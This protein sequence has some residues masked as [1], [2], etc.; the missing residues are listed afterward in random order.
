VN[1]GD[2][3]YVMSV[4]RRDFLGDSTVTL[5][6][7]G[8]CTHSRRYVDWELKA[9]LRQG[10]YYVPNGLLAVSL[11]SAP[12]SLHLPPRFQANWR[13]DGNGYAQWQAP[14]TQADQLGAWIE[15]AFSARTTRSHLISNS[16]DMMRNNARCL[17]CGSTHPAG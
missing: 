16:Q 14:P 10:D 13:Q 15:T 3:E 8:T 11:P 6:L 17:A 7:L 9:S 12:R 5:L 1:S 2:T 4:V